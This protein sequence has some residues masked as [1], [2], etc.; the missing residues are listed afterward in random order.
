MAQH[1]FVPPPEESESP[2]T[3]CHHW[4]I[5]P[6]DGPES[7]GVCRVCGEVRDFKNYVEGGKWGDTRPAV[8]PMAEGSGS[9]TVSAT[10]AQDDEE[11]E[12]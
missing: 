4:V 9:A 6:A 5:Q 2:P 11:E 1:L 7:R 3:C 8:S 12:G 10:E